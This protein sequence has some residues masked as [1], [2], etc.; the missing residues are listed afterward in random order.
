MQPAGRGPAEPDADV[1]RLHRGAVDQL[2]PRPARLD[3]VLAAVQP[4]LDATEQA[5]RAV[6]QVELGETGR[7][8]G[9]EDRAV[10]AEGVDAGAD[11][12]V[13]GEPGAVGERLQCQRSDERHPPGVL[14][15]AGPGD[16]VGCCVG[17]GVAEHAEDVGDL[18]PVGG[19]H[20]APVRGD[21]GERVGE[22]VGDAD[23]GVAG[24]GTGRGGEPE[25]HLDRTQRVTERA[26][27][28]VG[29]VLERLAGSVHDGVGGGEVEGGVRR[30]VADLHAVGGEHEGEAAGRIHGEPDPQ[31]VDVDGGRGR[32]GRDVED[33]VA[34]DRAARGRPD[35]QRRQRGGRPGH[36]VDRAE[37]GAELCT[38]VAVDHGRGESRPDHRVAGRP[39]VDAETQADRGRPE[40]DLD[41]VAGRGHSQEVSEVADPR[42]ALGLHGE[43]VV[44]PR[45]QRGYP[46]VGRAA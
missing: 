9:L 46:L 16:R 30:S 42:L 22:E 23:G 45:R 26:E 8:R 17:E 39:R 15:R 32:G 40:H 34:V 20:R 27:Q 28:V 1:R 41:G 12:E 25:Q 38:L 21:G 33:P 37:L 4:G 43:Q 3:A 13:E 35:T 24:R 19:E 2:E 11:R 44:Q 36:E 7:D 31:G 14:R 29:D 5:G 6:L 10:L 18:G